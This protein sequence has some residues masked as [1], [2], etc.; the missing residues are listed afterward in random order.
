[1]NYI[2]QSNM[3]NMLCFAA[4]CLLI[5][6]PAAAK[7]KSVKTEP[8][9]N[10]E[11]I[12]QSFYEV[13][14]GS[15]FGTASFRVRKWLK[16]LTIYVEHETGDV[17][18]HDQLLDAHIKH[19]RSITG[20]KITR[21]NKKEAANI[22]FFFTSQKRMPQLIEDIVGKDSIQYIHGSVCLA[23]IN[24]NDN[25]EI[26]TGNVF[27]PIDQARMHGKLV[28]CIIEELT[29]VLGLVRDSDLVFPSIFN[30][31]SHNDLL[32]GLDD[33]LLR[34]L[35]DVEIKPG[36]TK[37]QL[38]PVIKRILEGYRSNNMIATANKRVQ[39]GDLYLML[40]Y[41]SK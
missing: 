21:V 41:R 40:G 38:H 31:R 15:E 5:T 26:I 25:G 24:A 16:P 6:A 23:N 20:L 27:I 33:I 3:L 28:T 37:K 22:R 9:H 30:D 1:M 34:I 35:H 7:E 10:I 36:M 13:A 32:T 2:R 11:Y 19:L 4:L 18:L 17:V 14:L 29:Q 39:Q 12:E 8:W